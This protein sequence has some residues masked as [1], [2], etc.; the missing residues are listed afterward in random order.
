M[1]VSVGA[2]S[3]L[4]E[5]GGCALRVTR[6]LIVSTVK[7]RAGSLSPTLPAWSTWV[8]TAVYVPS[9]RGGDE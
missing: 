7:L 6:G 9:D 4:T 2:V 1:P 8:A 3:L 5:A